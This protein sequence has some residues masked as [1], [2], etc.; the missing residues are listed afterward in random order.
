MSETALI[1]NVV[2]EQATDSGDGLTFTLHGV[3]AQASPVPVVCV[4]GVEAAAEDYTFDAGD[5]DTAASIVF[6]ASKSGKTVTCDY[7]WRLTCSAEQDLT[8]Y[9]LGRES[10]TKVMKDVNGRTMAVE[11]CEKVTSWQGL[12]V[13]DYADQA[14]WEE[15]RRIAETPGMTFDVVR[16]SLTTPLDRISNLFPTGHPKFR[17]IPGVPGRTQ[18][19]LAAVQ[20]G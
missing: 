1:I 17:E 16:G 4:D 12:L 15:I 10:N 3:D 19:S 2:N 9:E 8:A 11:S 5:A 6:G 18:V 13:W 14:F 20:L 7:S